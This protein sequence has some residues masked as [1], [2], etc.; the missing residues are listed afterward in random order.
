MR[1]EWIEAFLTTI[2][3]KSFTKASELLNMTQPALSKQIRNLEADV[4]AELFARST[5]GVNL[6][7]AGEQLVPVSETIRREWN[8]VKRAI[9]V[10]QGLKGI[11]IGAWPS[12][13]TSYL[14]KK[15]ACTNRSDYSLRISHSY[16]DLLELLKEGKIDVALFDDTGIDQPFFS[17]FLFAEGFRLYVHKD[18]PIYGERDQ[19]SFEEIKE[20]EFLMLLETC[21]AR[22]L[23]QRE[24]E[25]RGA[26]LHISSEIEFGQSILGFIEANIGISILP[27]IFSERVS[28]DIRAIPIENF[29]VKRK[30]SIIARDEK[31][32]KKVLAMVK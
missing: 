9:A 17:T 28:P 29:D 32:G 1:I 25:E 26:K 2:E 12:V 13:A 6:T 22:R 30:V 11:T 19:V 5:T 7:K 24:F 31:V 27:D 16:V 20:D 15:L 18:H 4:G 21:D 3:T 8:E 10:E 23:I 14:P